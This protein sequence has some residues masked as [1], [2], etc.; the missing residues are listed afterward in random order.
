[1]ILA[2]KTDSPDVSVIA[3]QEGKQVVNKTWQAGRELSVQ[4]N[5]AIDEVCSEVSVQLQDIEG[6][7]V[8]HGPGSYT[9]LRIGVSVAN[10]LGLSYDIPVCGVSGED[11]LTV[12]QKEIKNLKK[13]S[14]VKV[15][16]GSDVYTTKP[17]K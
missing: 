12:G 7:I 16:Y 13:F 5:K 15:E 11:W 14:A 4:L 9:G 2:L 17:K 10:A 6:V 3:L 1:M 8:Y